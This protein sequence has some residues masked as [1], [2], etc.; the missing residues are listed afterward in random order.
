L[1][2]IDG[3]ELAATIVASRCQRWNSCALQPAT[4]R[5]R[6]TAQTAVLRSSV[7]T[8]RKTDRSSGAVR[9]EP[10]GGR[11]MIHRQ[12]ATAWCATEDIRWL[13]AELSE[14]SP[15]GAVRCIPV[16]SARG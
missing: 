3:K 1:R 10:V 15:S 7:S 5:A 6:G 14:V 9:A 4:P 13:S 2:L 8:T 16:V 12:V 11:S